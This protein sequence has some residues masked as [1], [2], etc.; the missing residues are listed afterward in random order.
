MSDSANP[1]ETKN[2][3]D[4][5]HVTTGDEQTN[6]TVGEESKK[7]S[8]NDDAAKASR[9]EEPKTSNGDAGKKV[10]RI[11]VTGEEPKSPE[12]ET[13]KSAS[14]SSDQKSR[15]AFSIPVTIHTQQKKPSQLTKKQRAE[16]LKQEA[17]KEFGGKRYAAAIQLYNEAIN[18]DPTNHLLYSNRAAARYNL[19]QEISKQAEHPDARDHCAIHSEASMS[20]NAATSLYYGGLEDALKAIEIEPNFMKAYLR[21]GACLVAL[22][23][24]QAAVQTYEATLTRFPTEES[25]KT[26][27]KEAK[28]KAA[29]LEEGFPLYHSFIN[30]VGQPRVPEP[31]VQEPP[32][33][34][35]AAADEAAAA[36]RLHQ[37]L[38]GKRNAL[39]PTSKPETRWQFYFDTPPNP[40]STASWD[41][42][43]QRRREAEEDEGSYYYHQEDVEDEPQQQYHRH[44]SAP[45]VHF[46]RHAHFQRSPPPPTPHFQRPSFQQSSHQ[47]SQPQS[48]FQQQ[49]HYQPHHQPYPQHTHYQPPAPVSQSHYQPNKK[50]S[51][52]TSIPDRKATNGY[53]QELCENLRVG[54]YLPALLEQGV[55]TVDDLMLLP[56]EAIQS[57]FPTL[58]HQARVLDWLRK[59]KGEL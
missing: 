32:R 50:R 53:L 41:P 27:L 51:D 52:H 33:N 28:E 21:V 54:Q 10:T 39:V 42:D 18:L 20:W 57:I 17:N 47:Q 29:K 35:A 13:K 6:T 16:A 11:P 2:E 7:K 1:N 14:P 24:Y 30:L 23:K 58:G 45:H 55:E 12:H 48:H 44:Q 36:A 25:V 59:A 19:A 46:Q 4:T 3:D 31:A 9:E 15:E 22:G 8:V 49:P 5:K 38:F 43:S 26:A 34:A 56:P 37:K 40:R